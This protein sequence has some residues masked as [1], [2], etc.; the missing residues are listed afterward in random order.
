MTNIF[1]TNIDFFTI[2][3][4]SEKMCDTKVAKIIPSLRIFY[5]SENTNGLFFRHNE[6]ICWTDIIVN[7]R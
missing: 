6:S 5:A 4:Y 2:N 3:S 1:V 7:I